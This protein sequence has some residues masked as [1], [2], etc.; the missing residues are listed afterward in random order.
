VWVALQKVGTRRIYH[1]QIVLVFF[2]LYAWMLADEHNKMILTQ[3]QM[4][5]GRMAGTVIY[6]NDKYR[7]GIGTV[8]RY[9]FD[10]WS[11]WRA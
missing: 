9:A 3:W 8:Q 2:L 5:E 10:V 1:T 4:D 11:M 7:L 6:L